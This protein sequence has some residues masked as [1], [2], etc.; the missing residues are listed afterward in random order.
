MKNL[1]GLLASTLAIVAMIAF[2]IWYEASIW[3]ECLQTN[4][5]WYC[6]RIL[7]H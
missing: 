6:F 1:I 2:I 5:W 4:S 3:S 7:S